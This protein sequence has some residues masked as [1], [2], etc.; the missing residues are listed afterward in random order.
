MIKRISLIGAPNSGKTTLYNWLTDSKFKTVNYPG[1]T[2]EMSEGFTADRY[3][4]PLFIA[5]TPGAYSLFPKSYD[6]QIAVESLYKHP[7][8]GPTAVVVAVV[9][10]T[11]LARHLYIVTQ[12]KEANF[13][14]VLALTNG[15]LLERQN[16]SCDIEKLKDLLDLPAARVNGQTGE[17]AVSLIEAVRKALGEP[18]SSPHRLEKWSKE[19]SELSFRELSQIANSVLQENASPKMGLSAYERSK[20]IDRVLMHPFWGLVL[21]VLFMTG[22]FTSIFWAAAPLMDIVN[23]AFAWMGALASSYFPDSLLGDFISNGIFAGVGSVLVFLPQIIILFLGICYF[24]DSG[25]LARAASLIDRPLSKIGLNGRS[26]VPIL[27]AYACAI[28]AMMAA[29]TISSKKE[30][31]ITLFILPLMSCSARLPVYALFLS[32]LLVDYPA[33]MGGLALTGIYFLSLII[34]AV[35]SAIANRMLASSEKSFFMLELPVYRR[36]HLRTVLKQTSSRVW[37][38]VVKAGPIIFVLSMLIWVGC[39]FPRYDVEDPAERL[40]HSYFAKA[41]EWIEPALEP[42]GI[43]W[44]V[45]VGLISAFAAR[46]VFVSSLAIVFNITEGD[47]DQVQVSLLEKMQTAIGPDGGPLFTVASS[48]GLI[49]F[50]MIALQC[51]ATVGVARREFGNWKWA[52][53][54]LVIFNFVAYILSVA[55]VQGLR[56]F[57]IS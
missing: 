24:E 27:S 17:G 34:G 51:M 35:A 11:Q 30:R 36:P 28:P 5:D 25:Y 45:G 23:E 55:L 4:E 12:L 44:R 56:A 3:G 47:E 29:R 6:E 33:W 42:M 21:F 43:D 26:F 38:Y 48:L 13:N 1:A 41:G 40:T 49:L 18:E 54:Q 14:I 39:T 22:L 52:I 57:G 7:S 31:F 46:E 53:T 10:L 37:G 50:F 16:R 32:F 9:D 2:V 8:H 15:D 19:K 20:K